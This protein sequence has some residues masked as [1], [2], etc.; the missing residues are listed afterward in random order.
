MKME[1]MLLQLETNVIQPKIVLVI[2]PVILLS[3]AVIYTYFLRRMV[4]IQMVI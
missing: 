3:M 2:V 4:L 1:S